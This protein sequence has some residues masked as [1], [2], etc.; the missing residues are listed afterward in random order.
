MICQIRILK[1]YIY[2]CDM[3]RKTVDTSTLMDDFSKVIR[4][5][6]DPNPEY[7]AETQKLVDT[8]KEFIQPKSY[9]EAACLFEINQKFEFNKNNTKSFI[10]FAASREVY[11][12]Y[13]EK[14]IIK[15]FFDT[16][17]EKAFENWIRAK[18]NSK[19]EQDIYIS[20]FTPISKEET[21]KRLHDTIFTTQ[22][23]SD[24]L[25]SLFSAYVFYSFP[26][27]KTHKYFCD[28]NMESKAEYVPNYF[29]YLHNCLGDKLKRKKAL[30]FIVVNDDLVDS[31][32]S[33]QE[34]KDSLCAFI[35]NTHSSLSN[36]CYLAVY[37]DLSKKYK[38]FK[39]ELYADIVLY[40]E[41]FIEERLRIG[42]FHPNTIQDST[43]KY[44]EG[45]NIE[46][47]NFKVA[48]GG[49]SY[50]DC[51][52]LSEN[53]LKINKNDV[54]FDDNYS[55][56]VLFEKNERD[57][58]IIP[59]PA[60]RSYNVRGN[61][62]PV[63][64]VKSWECNN[65]LCPDK[66]KFNRGKRY[67]LTSLI[68]QEAILD[69]ANEIKNETIK[70]WQ[71]DVLKKPE[72]EIILEFLI[73]HYT[74]VNDTIEIVDYLPKVKDQFRRNIVFIPF[75]RVKDGSLENFYNSSFFKRFEIRKTNFEQ[76]TFA[77]ISPFKNH[78]IFHGDSANILRKL[79]IDS[80]D[81]A[82]TSP[83]YY[84]AREYSQWDNIYCYLYDMYN[85]AIGVFNSL[86]PGA[87]Y[88]YNIFDYFDNENNIVFSA[89]GKK[90]MILGAYII[91]LFKKAGFELKNNIIWYKGHI[92]GN[93]S[94]NQG[95][96]F[97][98]YQAPLNCYE[99]IFEF[100]KPGN[101]K[102]SYRMPD[103]IYVNPVH[104]IVKGEN[105][106]GH[107]APFPKELPNLLL[108]NMFPGEKILDPY[109]GS[110]TTARTASTLGVKSISIEMN[111]IYCDLG[112]N[113]IGK[114]NI[115]ERLLF[116]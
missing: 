98:Y 48:N 87:T 71:L 100:V 40:A 105:V 112:V 59:C 33:I 18:F 10:D 44:I 74:L 2:L 36:H 46:D 85:N 29:E 67:S 4:W 80:I 32:E 92:Q 56:L 11:F 64:G 1:N 5:K 52:I 3:D 61:S 43:R 23:E 41:K 107:T 58:T 27:E 28:G 102:E 89:M 20:Q 57:E 90:R 84:N 14:N 109:A 104:K 77:N 88:L 66:S 68:K 76:E 103:I 114:E 53:D 93:R 37:I 70:K 113:L 49:F 97:P 96:P 54:E 51:F 30:S 25:H 42:Y 35:R 24:I 16:S 86:K 106:L 13:H 47:A 69:E 75:E 26:I 50:K 38:D 60:C 62:Y 108:R 6:F 63:I 22:N 99:H 82:I 17:Q 34:F 31:C 21:I 39:W 79:K 115:S 110:F 65:I 78:E 73:K 72:K 9:R 8:C 55:L 15:T 83:P 19:N 91:H 116:V 12:N 101:E 94:F 81:A 7:K 45:L 95:N 111:K